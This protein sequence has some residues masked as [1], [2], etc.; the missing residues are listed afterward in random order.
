MY[1]AGVLRRFDPVSGI[2][3]PPKTTVKSS[4]ISVNWDSNPH[5]PWFA[6]DDSKVRRGEERGEKKRKKKVS[7]TIS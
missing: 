5:D 6:P 7:M 3:K 1:V 2:S 4:Y